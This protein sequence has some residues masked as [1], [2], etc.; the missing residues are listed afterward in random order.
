MFCFALFFFFTKPTTNYKMT[1]CRRLF[2]SAAISTEISFA[3]IIRALTRL[4]ILARED[5]AFSALDTKQTSKE[6]ESK[7]FHSFLREFKII[8]KLLLR[9]TDVLT[10]CYLQ[11]EIAMEDS[12]QQHS[13]NHQ[14]SPDGFYNRVRP[15]FAGHDGL[16][17]G[18]A[19]QVWC[20]LFV[21]VN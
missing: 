6:D 17:G 20:W 9:T 16:L 4:W 21:F 1:P 14:I 11:E 8:A 7:Y 10:R 5:S 12:G 2:F 15:F 13:R 18:S 19:A 3:P